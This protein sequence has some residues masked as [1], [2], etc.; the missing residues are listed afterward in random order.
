MSLMEKLKSG[1][2]LRK[3]HWKELLSVLFILLAVY[4]F[5]QQRH[6][7]MALMPAIER[8]NRF[9]IIA[10]VLLTAGYILLQALMYFYSFKS[11][12][13]QL[14]VERST[15]LFLKRNLLSIF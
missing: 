15:E 13:S 12:G 6:E 8:A 14:D 7:L 11:V 5:R 9:W 4:F 3:L 10:G 1:S 2:L